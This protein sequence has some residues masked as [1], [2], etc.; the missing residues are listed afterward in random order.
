MP[1]Q[2]RPSW[3]PKSSSSGKTVGCARSNPSAESNILR[4]I[5][6]SRLD[7]C[8]QYSLCISKFPTL[9][10]YEIVPVLSRKDKT[11]HLLHA[12][13]IPSKIRSLFSAKQRTLTEKLTHMDY[14]IS[15]CEYVI[16]LSLI[17]ASLR[18]FPI[19][20]ASFHRS[21]LV[22]ILPRTMSPTFL[23]ALMDESRISARLLPILEISSSILSFRSRHRHG[24]HWIFCPIAARLPV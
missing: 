17:M 7:T 15:Q 5:N 14:N 8:G 2:S 3:L 12:S 6:R 20:Q 24:V 23:F 18:P 9:L 1:L 16:R 19:P 11:L 4:V 13:G 10:R 22:S 21:E